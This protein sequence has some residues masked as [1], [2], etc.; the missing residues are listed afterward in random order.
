MHVCTRQLPMAGHRGGRE[1]RCGARERLLH[2]EPVPRPPGD[3][4]GVPLPRAAQR[5]PAS[6]PAGARAARREVFPR[7]KVVFDCGEAQK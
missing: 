7:G 2:A 1:A 4:T 6:D 5:G 3:G